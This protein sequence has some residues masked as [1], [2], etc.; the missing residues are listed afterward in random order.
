MNFC[1]F[2]PEAKAYKTAKTES[3]DISVAKGKGG[4][5]ST[6][7]TNRED[8]E[9]LASDIRYIHQG[10]VQMRQRGE[11]YFATAA[12]WWSYV[13]PLLALVALIVAFRKKAMEN[14]NVAKMRNK[15]ASKAATKRL[16][17]A[18]VLL[19]AGKP[20]EF[21][22]EVLKALWGY[23]GDKLNLPA[24]ELNKEN[25][26]EKLQAKGADEGL[27]RRLVAIYKV[28]SKL[29]MSLFATTFS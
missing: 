24:A 27:V 25:V 19:K 11:A 23:V 3:F 14:A 17:Q 1:Y 21:Y 13:I 20:A 16:K 26:S 10:D 22:E 7:L 5:T 28:A 29:I 4:G 9:L 8:V 15:K 2:D 18:A 12:Y 6:N